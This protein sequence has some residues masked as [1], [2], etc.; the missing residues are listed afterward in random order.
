MKKLSV[1]FIVM[2]LSVIFAGCASTSNNAAMSPERQE[3]LQNL[4]IVAVQTTGRIA[5]RRALEE[6][7][8]WIE[9]TVA[10]SGS[11]LALV[12]AD[13]SISLLMLNKGIE[14]EIS[15]RFNPA[16]IAAVMDVVE[17]IRVVV[18]SEIEAQGIDSNDVMV[19]V[20][21]VLEA[22]NETATLTQAY[23]TAGGGD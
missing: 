20:L 12:D 2:I 7:P 13:S 17:S 1:F 6:H 23:Y 10:V 11:A 5:V 19:R 14:A 18:R 4:A 21:D 22:I 16:D 9:P 8:E 3:A 15:E